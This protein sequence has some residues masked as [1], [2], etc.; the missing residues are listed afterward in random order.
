VLDVAF[1]PD[2]RQVLTTHSDGTVR[3]WPTDDETVI[4]LAR[5]RLSRSFT[6]QERARYA[7]L[8]DNR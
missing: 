2:G 4:E 5:R 6:D 3:L 1:S 7:S 8:L